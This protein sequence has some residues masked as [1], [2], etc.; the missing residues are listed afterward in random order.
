M[1]EE[2]D[3]AAAARDLPALAQL[4]QACVA[5]GASINFVLP[6]TQDDSE[7]WWRRVVLPA[8]EAGER[9]LL[10]TRS[11]GRIVGSVQL[12]LAPQPNQHHRA[13]ITKLLVDPV[14]RRRG[15]A[16]ALM[17]RVEEVAQE[18]GRTL[19]TL[20]TVA[21]SAAEQ[22]YLSLGYVAF[23]SIPRF[24]RAPEAPRYEAASFFYKE[25]GT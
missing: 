23:G 19:L 11:G 22:L 18:E 13:D 14:A 16:R 21:G 25:L 6:F 9:R 20:D 12:A 5:G 17:Q 8:M 10:V 7:A 1:I 4:M 3:A 15:I 24:A 2:L